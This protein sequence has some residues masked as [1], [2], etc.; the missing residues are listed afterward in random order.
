VGD[1]ESSGGPFEGY[2]GDLARRFLLG[3][4]ELRPQALLWLQ[5]ASALLAGARA[6]P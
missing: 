2:H 1:A 3:V 6:S 4:R 5:R